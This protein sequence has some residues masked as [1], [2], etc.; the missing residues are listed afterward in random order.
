[1]QLDLQ[2]E[3]HRPTRY[4]EQHD[5]LAQVTRCHR[6]GPFQERET[7]MSRFGPVLVLAVLTGAPTFCRADDD[8]PV[9]REVLA[10][11]DAV[12]A[13]IKRAEPAVACVLV[14]RSDA[15]RVL[16]HDSP[17]PDSPGKLGAFDDSRRDP[18]PVVPRRRGFRLDDVNARLEEEKRK[19]D[20]SLAGTVPEAFG[21]GVVLDG[22]ELLILTNYHVVR[23]ATKIYVRLS[24]GKGSYADIRAADPRSDLAI[25]QLLDTS[26]RPL[27]AIKLGDGAAA[28]KGQFVVAL[29]NPFAAGFRDGGPSASWG[30]LSNIQRGAAPWPWEVDEDPRR[31][32]SK[33]FFSLNTLLQTDAR[34]NL[35]CSGGALLN[36]RGE[37]IGLTSARAAV[38]GS[39][40][41]GGFAVPVDVAFR[42][43]VEKLRQGVEVEYGFLGVGDAG[44]NTSSRST[45]LP[46]GGVLVKA[47]PGSPAFHAS[48]PDP[49]VIESINGIPLK[50]YD[51]L[52]YTVCTLLAGTEVRLAVRDRPQIIP[53]TLA[54]SYVRGK[55]LV[56]RRPEVV[57]GIRVDYT[58]VL[59]QIQQLDAQRQAFWGQPTI[60]PGV[61]IC[62]LQPNTPAAGLLKVNDIITHLK[63][64]GKEV[65]VNN[66]AE[67]YREAA[68]L[69]PGEPLE[70]TLLST[71]WQRPSSPT[72]II[73]ANALRDMQ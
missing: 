39:E 66:P 27:Q 13:A 56:S 57:R 30:I 11:Q 60:Y 71:N 9:S 33:S 7:L 59:Y 62:E 21:S 15:Y 3:I 68:K 22:Q 63:V 48:L 55:I 8:V 23:D 41:S 2:L 17:P 38:T 73:P 12:R 40:T 52:Y 4:K 36:L 61:Y 25:L 18:A 46:G 67:F 42:R 19:Y 20:L 54:K 35:G 72:V 28:D 64:G 24:G 37:M 49:A 50:D 29:S 70:L 14:S 6:L 58:S 69:P 5:R 53:V 51:D 32:S 26:L 34:L 65:E 43:I 1:M 10:L 16:F 44:R 47:V 31:L 45:R